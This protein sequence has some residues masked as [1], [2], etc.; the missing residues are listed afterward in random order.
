MAPKLLSPGEEARLLWW[1]RMRTF[2]VAV[3]QSLSTARLRVTLVVVLSIIFWFGLF[4]LFGAGFEFLAT[5]IG[6]PGTHAQTVHAIYNVFFA[7]LLMML[8]FSSA[9]ILYGGLYWSSEAEFLLTTPIRAERIVLHKFQ[10]AIVFSSWGF[11]LLGS[12]MLVAYGLQAGAPW[13]YFALLLPFMAAFVYIPGGIGAI[14]CMLFVHRL[15]RYQKHFAIVGAA[16]AV[17]AIVMFGWSMCQKTE[18]NLLTPLW[19][20]EMLGR[21]EFS[22]H[23]LL[24]SWWLSSGLLEAARTDAGPPG[25]AAW[26]ESVKFLSLLI[27]NALFL[28]V[29]A[30]EIGGR[31]YRTSYSELRTRRTA[32]PAES[33]LLARPRVM[34]ATPLFSPQLRLLI[35]KDLRLFRRD[36]VQWS[37][38]II[39]FGL[40]S[41]YFANIRRFSYDVNYTAWVNMISFL[42]LA[43]V[44]LIL[45]T[46]TTRFIFPMLSLEGRRFWI[47]S[48]LPVRRDA[49]LWGKF[50]FAAAGSAHS[51]LLL[52]LLS[53][54]MLQ[55]SP[56]VVVIHQLTCL[57]LCLGLSG[58]AVGLGAKM[59]D[60]REESPSK[61]AAGFGGTL[62]LVISAIYIVTV[63]LLTACHRTF[64]W[65]RQCRRRAVLGQCLARGR[66]G[67][68]LRRGGH[69][70]ARADDDRAGPEFRSL[71]F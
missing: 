2:W 30:V 49:I 44:G 4:R 9:I 55:I 25:G 38:F 27:S 13:Y 69:C 67:R 51:L 59:P 35:V 21:L 34:R 56:L 50:W 37:Q 42:N 66:H 24:P 33:E 20:Q 43:V 70:H 14:V 26:A 16:L 52:I 58:I 15:G 3:R 60:L 32:A 71:E 68:R 29:V 46:F 57:L 64:T 6:H 22:E 31:I 54:L 28:R 45:S 48:M 40:L 18:G 12:P 17:L 11:L 19:F 10:E 1:V 23:R 62:S 5:T 7:S 65:R 63:V 8:V 53:D 61:I 47:L 36:P 41:L 39:F